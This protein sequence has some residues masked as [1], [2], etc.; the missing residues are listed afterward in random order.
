LLTD[1]A[2][3][4]VTFTSIVGFFVF[5]GSYVMGDTPAALQTAY[6]YKYTALKGFFAQDD[7]SRIGKDFDYV[8]D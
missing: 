8:C 7:P 4:S 2:F 6:Y 3:S 1:F 5:F